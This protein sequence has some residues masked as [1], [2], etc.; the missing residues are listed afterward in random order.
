MSNNKFEKLTKLCELGAELNQELVG[1]DM[2][3]IDRGTFQLII[4][5]EGNTPDHGDFFVRSKQGHDCWSKNTASTHVYHIISG[6]G[7]FLFSDTNEATE[8]KP[9][10]E[11]VVI[12]P[13]REFTYVGDMVMSFTMEPNYDDKNNVPNKEGKP[14]PYEQQETPIPTK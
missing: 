6:K 4:P 9:G 14:V 2:I 7:K 8:V 11:D 13:N 12:E 3:F 1:N 5:K 10:C